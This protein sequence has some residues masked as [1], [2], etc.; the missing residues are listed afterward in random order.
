M[1]RLWRQLF[2]LEKF[3]LPT[4]KTG[5]RILRRFGWCSMANHGRGLYLFTI[6]RMPPSV[7]NAVVKFS[8]SPRVAIIGFAENVCVPGR[9]FPS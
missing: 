4:R 5:V 6:R 1:T 2:A 3:D 8:S 7:S 9:L